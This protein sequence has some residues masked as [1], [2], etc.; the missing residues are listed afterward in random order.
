M[1]R[2]LTEMMGGYLD[3][4]EGHTHTPLEVPMVSRLPG[5]RQL[6]VVPKTSRWVVDKVNKCLTRT[7][8]FSDHTRMCDFMRE[9]FDYESDTGHYAKFVCEYP[10][11]IV[12]VK[13]HDVDDVTELDKAYA[14]QC[15][16]IYDDILHYGTAGLEVIDEIY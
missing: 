3:E 13:T 16:Q 14:S 11:V 4:L 12:S 6:P 2:L 7:Y 15:D 8:E 10:D 5:N 1:R 9:V